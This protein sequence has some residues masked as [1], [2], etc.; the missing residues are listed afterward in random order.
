MIFNDAQLWDGALTDLSCW[1]YDATD[2]LSS[3]IPLIDSNSGII[4]WRVIHWPGQVIIPS[5]EQID[6]YLL[7]V[8][9]ERRPAHP[10]WNM[11]INN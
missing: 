4:D 6:E 8:D 3:V 1:E 11:T 10:L 9:I 7:C 2:S 5:G